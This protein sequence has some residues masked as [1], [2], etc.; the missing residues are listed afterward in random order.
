MFLMQYFCFHFSN[1]TLKLKA[2]DHSQ[3]AGKENLLKRDI[4]QLLVKC[5]VQVFHQNRK[6]LMFFQNIF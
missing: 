6:Q 1:H 2:P 3:S 5:F 4:T